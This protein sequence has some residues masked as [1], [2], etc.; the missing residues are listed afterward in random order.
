YRNWAKCTNFLSKLPGDVK[1]R[2]AAAEEVTL[3][4]DRDLR[5]KKP[6]EEV[7]RYS[8]KL[9]RQVAVE[10]LLNLRFHYLSLQPIQAFEHPKFKELIDVASCATSGI[11]IPGRKATRAEIIRMFKNHLTMLK[12]QLKVRVPLVF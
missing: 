9:F 10:W 8:D 11:N 7:I 2:K 12:A 1:M 6:Y 4:L 3:T 5:E